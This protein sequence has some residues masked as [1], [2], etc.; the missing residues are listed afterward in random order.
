MFIFNKINQQI[1]AQTKTIKIRNAFVR[2]TK[3]FST[4]QLY[5][6]HGHKNATQPPAKPNLHTGPSFKHRTHN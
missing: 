5:I 6:Q 3:L 1:Q 4:Q 2:T